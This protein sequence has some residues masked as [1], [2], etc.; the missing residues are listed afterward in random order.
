MMLLL[1]ALTT[2]ICAT[3]QSC[4]Q[5][6]PEI[7]GVPEALQTK[8]SGEYEYIAK[9]R[10]YSNLV[11]ELFAELQEKDTVLKRIVGQQAE[12]IQ[13]CDDGRLNLFAK[14]AK[15]T[16]YYPDAR[17][18]ASQIAD[19]ST[20]QKAMAM[21]DLS[22]ARY[23]ADMAT[24]DALAARLQQA[25]QQLEDELRMLKIRLTLPQIEDYQRKTKPELNAPNKILQDQ[26]AIL[27]KMQQF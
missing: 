18:H 12:M 27:Q 16:Q 23:K 17:L 3:L 19:S 4:Q 20:A 1:L 22:E 10:G 21:I 6:T 8:G 7:P 13:R 25:T 24:R 15:N 11:D 2:G 14:D 5:K 26:K 9:G